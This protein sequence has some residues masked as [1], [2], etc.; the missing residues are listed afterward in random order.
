MYSYFGMVTSGIIELFCVPHMWFYSEEQHG[1][2]VKSFSVNKYD[3]TDLFLL[4][5]QLTFAV[6]SFS[7]PA[8]EQLHHK[9]CWTFCIREIFSSR[10]LNDG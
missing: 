3:L 4:G 2:N 8:A 5:L 6:V 9:R 10:L 1:F 7:N